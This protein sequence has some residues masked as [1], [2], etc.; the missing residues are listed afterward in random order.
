MST[1]CITTPRSAY[2]NG[3][4]SD[5]C[6]RHLQVLT[7]HINAFTISVSPAHFASLTGRG[8]AFL[9]EAHNQQADK[10]K[11]SNASHG[12]LR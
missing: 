1:P 7:I 6:V 3:H 4:V 9:N 2:R 10:N 5:P 11:E 8:V 12:S